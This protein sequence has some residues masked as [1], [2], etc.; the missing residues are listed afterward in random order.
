MKIYNVILENKEN[1]KRTSLNWVAKSLG[2]LETQ[3]SEKYDSLNI[4]T[5]NFIK[6][7][8]EI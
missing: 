5:V 4:I 6:D 3:L 1:K 7:E 2:D 8:D